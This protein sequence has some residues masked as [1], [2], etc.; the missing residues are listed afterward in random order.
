MTLEE[1][2]DTNRLSDLINNEDSSQSIADRLLNRKSFMKFRKSQKLVHKTPKKILK[3]ASKKLKNLN[4]TLASH[5]RLW[6]SPIMKPIFT[7]I[8]KDCT[9][10]SD[11]NSLEIPIL[12]LLDLNGFPE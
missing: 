10:Y 5:S 12:P 9:F 2:L 1:I 11:E 7:G 6:T 8:S 3:A 4:G